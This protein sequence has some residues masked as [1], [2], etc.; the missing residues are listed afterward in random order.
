MDQIMI[1]IN[2][3]ENITN[4]KIEL[5]NNFNTYVKHNEQDLSII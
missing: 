2:L 3:C 5:I 4:Q 1:F